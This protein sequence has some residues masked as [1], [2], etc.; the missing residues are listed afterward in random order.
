MSKLR[1]FLFKLNPI[2]LIV[3]VFYIF[4]TILNL[5]FYERIPHSTRI[6]LSN[7]FL[8]F[9]VFLFAY[10]DTYPK[11]NTWTHLHRWYIAPLIF[12]SFKELYWMVKPIRQID[13]DNILINIDRFLLGGDPTKF[14]HQISNP[15]LT[16]LLQ[17]SYATFFFLPVILGIELL[18]RKKDDQFYYTTFLVLLGFFLSYIGYLLVPAIGPRFTLHNFTSINK[19]LPGLFFTDYLRDYVNIGESIP[20]GTLNPALFVQRDVFPSGHTQMTL[21]VMYLAVKLKSRLKYFFL[22]DGSLL[23]FS[24]V[25]LWYHYVIDLIGGVIFMLFTIWSGIRIYNWWENYRN[26][27]TFKFDE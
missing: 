25:Y 23:I 3:I 7:F 18:V 14:L 10:K 6:V 27:K 20:K 4:L 17:I 24:T 9:I 16:E 22:I 5:I 8:F 1:S 26:G 19:D 12:L 21:I 11:V 15:I 13:Y 2:D